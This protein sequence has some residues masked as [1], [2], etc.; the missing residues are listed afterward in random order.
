LF[1]G[2]SS[3]I[4]GD[5]TAV[6]QLRDTLRARFPDAVPLVHRLARPVPTGIVQLDGL[7]PDGGLPRG[8]LTEWT[9]G[10]GA[11][12]VLR[13]ACAAVRE[14]GERAAWVD[15]AGTLADSPAG[16]LL[17][18]PPG[19]MAGLASAEELLRS[20]GFA[21]V[22]LAGAGRS[23]GREGVRLSRSA[24]EGGAAFVV[25]GEGAPIAHLR[26]ASRIEPYDYCW[27]N[28]PFGEPA[29]VVAVTVRLSARS[30]GWS[31]EISFRLPVF[32]HRQRQ[33]LDPILAD[34]RGVRWRRKA[35]MAWE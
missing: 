6:E 30:L 17:V 14:H 16:P 34:R 5:M 8:R 18:R 7:L 31:G 33:A 23:L 1:F 4:L 19:E 13:A 25:L 9:P 32:A 29:D 22:V 24:R 28:D 12:A 10:G 27:R 21:L 20:G 2:L 35:A 3:G 26:V 11:T 15:A